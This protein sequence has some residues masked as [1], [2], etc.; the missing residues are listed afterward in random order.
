MYY[1]KRA[2]PTES[3]KITADITKLLNLNFSQAQNVLKS[4]VLSLDI[5]KQRF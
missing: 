2:L 1:F 4:A 5:H 3:Y